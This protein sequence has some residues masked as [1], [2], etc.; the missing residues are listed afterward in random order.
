MEQLPVQ[1]TRL[2]RRRLLAGAAAAAGLGAWRLAS[3][4]TAPRPNIL[5]FLSDDMGWDQ[6]GFNGSK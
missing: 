4:Q 6:V 2:S 1:T 3:G 5:L